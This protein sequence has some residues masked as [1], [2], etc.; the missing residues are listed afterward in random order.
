[1]MA[2]RGLFED[3]DVIDAVWP[4][5][6]VPTKHFG[7]AED[8]CWVALPRCEGD[9]WDEYADALASDLTTATMW[10]SDEANT[11]SI[12]MGMTPDQA[13]FDLLNKVVLKERSE[14]SDEGLTTH[15]VATAWDEFVKNALDSA[16]DATSLILSAAEVLKEMD[17]KKG[18]PQSAQTDTEIQ[19]EIFQEWK[20]GTV[21]GIL[22]DA[23]AGLGARLLIDAAE[24]RGLTVEEYMQRIALQ[25]ETMAAK[26]E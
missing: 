10:F 9:P 22:T 12:G 4:V 13:W 16:R 17:E 26:W 3:L 11:N 8:C 25:R 5:A 24:A 14:S 1:M 18:F 23:L 20:V 7:E 15:K 21:A 6:V 2:T 19:G